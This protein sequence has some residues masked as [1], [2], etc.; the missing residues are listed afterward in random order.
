MV[1][2]FKAALGAGEQPQA[3]R[4]N[5]RNN[6]GRLRSEASGLSLRAESVAANK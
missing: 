1:L 4:Q 5:P 2:K 3:T 6:R